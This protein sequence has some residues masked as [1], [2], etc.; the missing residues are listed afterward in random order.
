MDQLA[1]FASYMMNWMDRQAKSSTSVGIDREVSIMS[2]TEFVASLDVD[3]YGPVRIG[4]LKSVVDY[5]FAEQQ[6]SE[7]E[8]TDPKAKKSDEPH[9]SV[10]TQALFD[11]FFMVINMMIGEN[12]LHRDDYHAVVTKTIE[13]RRGNRNQ[14]NFF[15]YSNFKMRSLSK[16]FKL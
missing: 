16:D 11:G 15:G 8:W 13:R 6:Q 1:G 5:V 3:N 4:E 2:G 14:K 9:L 12:Q 10:A 7:S